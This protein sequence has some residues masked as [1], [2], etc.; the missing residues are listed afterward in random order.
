MGRATEAMQYGK[1]GFVADEAELYT[2]ID[3][4]N[5]KI[6]KKMAADRRKAN[7]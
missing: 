5:P 2:H 7:K 1:D 6:R 4:N 3:I